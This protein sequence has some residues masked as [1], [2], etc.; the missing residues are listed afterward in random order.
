MKGAFCVM[1]VV[2]YGPHQLGP[3]PRS[4][5]WQWKFSQMPLLSNADGFAHAR[6]F[7]VEHKHG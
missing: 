2:C 7:M 6:R 5:Q 1:Q 4:L 3:L